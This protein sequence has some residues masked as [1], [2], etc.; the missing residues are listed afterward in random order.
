M[1]KRIFKVSVVF[2]TLFY[3]SLGIV[4][5]YTFVNPNNEQSVNQMINS[6][7]ES[8]DLYNAMF[9]LEDSE[10][11]LELVSS[12]SLWWPI[13]SAETTTIGGKL[14]ATGAP[15]SMKIGNG[16]GCGGDNAWRTTG[17]HRG[18]DI[19]GLGLAPGTI[20]II[21]SKDGTVVYPKKESQKQFPDKGY[22]GNP[23]GGGL[24]N[25]VIIQHSDG[26]YS[27]Y[28]HMAQNSITVMA[29]ETVRQGQ[30]IGKVGHSGSSTGPHLHYS[31]R[32]G[33]T[34]SSYSV[35]PMEYIDASNPRPQD[36]STNFSLLSSTL[37][38]DEF[39]AKMTSY[40]DRSKNTGFCNN[41]SSQSGDIYD[42]SVKNHV[43][44]ELVVVVAGAETNWTLDSACSYTNN[45][46]GIGIEK[47]GACN[48]G[49]VYS[50]LSAGVAEYA[51]LVS[52]YNPGGAYE[53][54]IKQT[55]STRKDA[56]CDRGGYGLPGSLAGMESVLADSFLG[57]YRYNPGTEDIGGCIWLNKV[58]SSNYCST[59]TTCTD[60]NSCP[61]ESRTTVCEQNDYT[62]WLT[63][64]KLKIRYDIF[65]L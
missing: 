43:N 26:I 24:G 23:D 49:G 1:L 40:C 29:G 47:G 13:G 56:G 59:V 54:K 21:A 27:V 51:R 60:Y 31:I 57:E 10:E 6:I 53:F 30:V 34:A 42:V 50:S 61:V 16:Y 12:N 9:G 39:I 44:P 11:L 15:Q 22:Y 8:K 14:F 33:G 65:G 4:E 18:V 28:G 45:Y 35:D 20:N 17:C 46:W 5:A 62:A 58:Y 25:Y 41:F 55:N 37:S 7:Y 32:V 38:R 48:S 3:F 19:S 52:K 2:I 63:S 36:N 64:K